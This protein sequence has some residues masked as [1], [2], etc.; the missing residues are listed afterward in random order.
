VK[1]NCSQMAM[2]L[3]WGQHWLWAG[4]LRGQSSN[5]G[6]IKNFLFS[7]ASR[8]DLGPTQLPSQWVTGD[9][10]PGDKAAGA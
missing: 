1:M 10:F 6:R 2:I 4:R 9:S 3:Y 7:A 8:V 5:P